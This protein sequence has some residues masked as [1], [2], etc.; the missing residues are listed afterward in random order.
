MTLNLT[1]VDAHLRE[2]NDLDERLHVPAVDLRRLTPDERAEHMARLNDRDSNTAALHA[3]LRT[4]QQEARAA[5]I[6]ELRRV[7]PLTDE[8]HMQALYAARCLHFSDRDE[9]LAGVDTYREL[10]QMVLDE[11]LAVQPPRLPATTLAELE[12]AGQPALNALAAC[13][14]RRA[15][16]TFPDPDTL[17]PAGRAALLEDLR[18]YDDA[19]TQV[20]AAEQTASEQRVI[21]MRRA[22]AQLTR[23]FPNLS[24]AQHGQVF[25]HLSTQPY[26]T[27]LT[28]TNFVQAYADLAVLFGPIDADQWAAFTD[29]PAPKGA[30]V[31]K[32]TPVPA[33]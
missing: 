6:A 1:V 18:T 14:A 3:R 8:V 21:L 15:Q 9:L 25:S 24:A 28:L 7:Y 16:L 23:V 27:T 2:M 31:L 32:G 20:R 19:N 22:W 29:L 26:F 13:Q 17:S 5:V 11:T 4:V 12:A 10:A 30:P 33:R